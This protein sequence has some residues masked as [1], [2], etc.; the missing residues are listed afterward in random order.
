MS[1]LFFLADWNQDK[2]NARRVKKYVVSRLCKCKMYPWAKQKKM[3]NCKTD[4]R[5][6]G[7]VIALLRLSKWRSIFLQF[8]NSILQPS[9]CFSEKK[10][11]FSVI[12]TQPKRFINCSKYV[13]LNILM[14]SYYQKQGFTLRGTTYRNDDS[15]IDLFLRFSFEARY[16]YTQTTNMKQIEHS[17]PH[18]FVYPKLFEGGFIP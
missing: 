6:S 16:C 14:E 5:C 15:I 2:I 1:V 17:T 8:Y 9:H 18:H 3:G 4:R 7:R 12:F 11:R 13:F 10:T